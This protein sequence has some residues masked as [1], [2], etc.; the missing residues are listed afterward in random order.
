MAHSS[1]DTYRIVTSNLGFRVPA[2]FALKRVAY[3]DHFYHLTAPLSRLRFPRLRSDI[4]FSEATD[5]DFAEI[6]RGIG[7]LD[8][9][10]ARRDVVTRVLFY[11]RG[12]RGSY[13]GRNGEGELVS[14][15]WLLRPRDT[16]LIRAHYPR[17][18]YPL[19]EGEVLLE[20][21]FI[22]PRFRG[23]GALPTVIHHVV[24]VAQREGFRACSTYIRK[25]N[26]AS[27][28]GFLTIGFQLQRL[29]TGYNLMGAAWRD[30]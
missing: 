3:L 23:I 27:L 13:V 7:A 8:A 12:F 11:R 22:Y 18:Y 30:L 5:A 9:P 26:L 28:N 6:A 1:L 15:I 14:L 20:N 25:D 24:S 2:L 21:L 29:L 10:A 19:R 17:V 4:A 16:P